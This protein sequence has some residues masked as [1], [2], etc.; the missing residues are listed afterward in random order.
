MRPGPPGVAV[1]HVARDQVIRQECKAKFIEDHP[2]TC[3][4]PP[5]RQLCDH[6]FFTHVFAMDDA[7]FVN[8]HFHRMVVT[9]ANRGRPQ[10]HSMENVLRARKKGGVD[11]TV[12]SD[13]LH[14]LARF[15]RRSAPGLVKRHNRYTAAQ[16]EKYDHLRICG[17]G[18]LRR[19]PLS[20]RIRNAQ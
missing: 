16:Q 12:I 9:A 13:P 5:R 17:D 14:V 10:L 2:H 1:H 7:A 4:R 6:R 8:S 11:A 3:T 20:S 15:G 18:Y 19:P